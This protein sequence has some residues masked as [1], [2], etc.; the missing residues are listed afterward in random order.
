[1]TSLTQIFFHVLLVWLLLLVFAE[2]PWVPAGEGDSVIS[3]VL[4][5]G[6]SHLYLSFLLLQRQESPAA[7]GFWGAEVQQAPSSLTRRGRPV[8]GPQV[9][10]QEGAFPRRARSV[11]P[12]SR[13]PGR[14]VLGCGSCCRRR[15]HSGLKCIIN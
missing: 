6:Q 13:R 10:G 11:S 4:S 2:E 8:T 15:G 7:Q 1:M 3:G 9:C 14:A 5:F 12:P